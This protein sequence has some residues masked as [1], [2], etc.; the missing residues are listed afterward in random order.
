MYRYID[1]MLCGPHTVKHSNN[2]TYITIISKPVTC[3]RECYAIEI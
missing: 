3:T 2:I 1:N